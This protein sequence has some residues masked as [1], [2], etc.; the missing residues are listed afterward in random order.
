VRRREF[1]TLLGGATA[2]PIAARA[3]QPD[4]MRRVGVLL[5]DNENDPEVHARLTALKQRLQE[6]DWTNGRNVQFEYRFTGANAERIRLG[7]VELVAVAPDVIL[8]YSSP[9][10]AALQQA[11]R[12][13]PIVFAQVANPVESGFVASLARPGGNTT[14]FLTLEPAMG[15]KWLEVL[16]QIAPGVRRVAFVHNPDQASNVAFLRAAEAASTSL[17]MTVTAAGVRNGTD[18]ERA[19]T[20]LALEPNGGLILAPAPITINTRKLI[21]AT[22]ARLGLPAIYPSRFFPT[23]GGLVSYGAGLIEQWRGAASYIDRILRG[24]KPAD[25]PVQGPTK[26]DLVINLKTA[27]ALGLKIPDKLLFTADEVIE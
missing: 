2:W 18:I 24:A 15:G 21:I 25:L 19:L 13:I 5:P 4:R 10:L 3:Q 14:G 17:G 22:A 12:T 23:S 27:K 26:F 7:A 8:V 9:A 16:K 11:T 20:A 1:I 6:L